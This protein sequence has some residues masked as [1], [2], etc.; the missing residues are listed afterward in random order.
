MTR[1]N[2]N[3]QSTSYTPRYLER[4]AAE[5]DDWH[6]QALDRRAAQR[7]RDSGDADT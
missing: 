4:Y 2:Q 5:V 3:P 6:R 1:S 7:R